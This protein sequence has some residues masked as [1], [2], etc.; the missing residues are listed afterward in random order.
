MLE[1]LHI[2]KI[3]R[4]FVADLKNKVTMWLRD[5]HISRITP[6]VG[7][8]HIRKHNRPAAVLDACQVPFTVI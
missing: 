4:T 5:N 2:C 7:I 8:S 3:I 6:S 1:R